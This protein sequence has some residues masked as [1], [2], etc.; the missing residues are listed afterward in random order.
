MSG[1]GNIAGLGAPRTFRLAQAVGP[2]TQLRLAASDAWE[3][4]AVGEGRDA[5]AVSGWR[6]GRTKPARSARL[7]QLAFCCLLFFGGVWRRMVFRV[8]RMTTAVL[9][10]RGDW[11]GGQG[12]EG[13]RAFWLISGFWDQNGGVLCVAPFPSKANRIGGSGMSL[14]RVQDGQVAEILRPHGVISFLLI[15]GYVRMSRYVM[16]LCTHVYIYYIYIYL[17]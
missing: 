2:G 5:G 8:A 16:H 9:F 3:L 7:R 17:L 12:A 4:R 14:Y 11:P 1:I 15:G 10:L 13:Y 6:D